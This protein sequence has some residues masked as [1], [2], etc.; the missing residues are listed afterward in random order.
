MAEDYFKDNTLTKRQLCSLLHNFFDPSPTLLSKTM[1]FLRHTWKELHNTSSINW[2]IT[3]PAAILTLTLLTLYS[4]FLESST[5]IKR[6]DFSEYPKTEHF[7]SG[8]SDASMTF[9]A[10]QIFLVSVLHDSNTTR[11]QLMS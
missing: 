1:L 5:I 7:I 11:I 4:F 2:D 6:Y 8:L 10:Y 3:I 9:H